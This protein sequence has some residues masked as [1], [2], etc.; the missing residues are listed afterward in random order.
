MVGAGA[1]CVDLV[2]HLCAAIGGMGVVAD[3]RVEV[4]G[5]EVPVLD[6]GASAF[7]RALRQLGF[8][9]SP[10]CTRIL[11]TASFRVGDAEY[12]FCPSEGVLLSVEVV[13]DHPLIEVKEAEWCGDPDDFLERIAPARTFGFRR[14]GEALRAAGRARSIDPRAVVVLEDDGT[15]GSAPGPSPDECVRHKLLDLVGDVTLAV[16][17]P[18]GTIR[19]YRSGHAATH[20]VMAM[21]CEAGV[22][23]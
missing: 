7:A 22:F 23:G 13:F 6:G 12:H 16:G 21:A 11:R 14:D 20:R 9:S 1:L 8:P 17:I 3:L 19:A 18:R 10:P 5:P 4:H 2:E 15:S